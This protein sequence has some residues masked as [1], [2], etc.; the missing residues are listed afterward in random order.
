MS[1]EHES[2][3]R[4]PASQEPILPAQAS[5]HRKEPAIKETAPLTHLVK[6]T[7]EPH[8]KE[9]DAF[10]SFHL[11]PPSTEAPKTA[12]I[13]ELHLVKQIE[14]DRFSSVEDIK[15]YLRE[16]EKNPRNVSTSTKII[17]FLDSLDTPHQ[18]SELQFDHDTFSL[19]DIFQTEVMLKN[20]RNLRIHSEHITQLPKLGGKLSHLLMLNLTGCKNLTQL[21]EMLAKSPSLELLFLNGCTQLTTLPDDASS[22]MLEA[23]LD[24]WVAENPSEERTATVKIL[25]DFIENDDFD[26]SIDFNHHPAEL[27]DI[28]NVNL[29]TE[30]AQALNI[31]SDHLT[32]LPSSIV[33][34]TSYLTYLGIHCPNLTQLP[35]INAKRTNLSCLDLQGST[36]LTALP[37]GVS[38][39]T[40]GKFNLSGCTQL[41]TL[42]DN[43][44]LPMIEAFLDKWALEGAPHENRAHTKALFLD[45]LNESPPRPPLVFSEGT[46]AL[47][48]I[49]NVMP[50]RQLQYLNI[51]SP[52]ITSLPPS[53]GRLADLERLDLHGCTGLTALPKEIGALTKLELLDLSNCTS[54]THL[55]LEIGLLKR[56]ADLSLENCSNLVQVPETIGE[57]LKLKKL[58]LE[59]CIALT[60]LPRTLGNLKALTEL[61]LCGLTQLTA[62]PQELG[63]LERLLRL[64]LERCTQLTEV[65]SAI[66][67]L[68]RLKL[69]SLAGCTGLTTISPEIGRLALLEIF[70]LQDC[71]GLVFLPETIGNLKRL[72]ALLLKGC[73]AFDKL[74]VGIG[75]LSSLI[76]LQL[77][78]TP[79]TYLP[80]E[81]GHLTQLRV[82]ELDTCTHLEEIPE[83]LSNLTH[84]EL[85]QCT[86][87]SSLESIPDLHRLIA[88]ER[89][90]LSDC[91]KLRQLPNVGSIPKLEYLNLS[92]LTQMT[93]VSRS[94]VSA[95]NI[96]VIDL[97]GCSHLIALPDA[98]GTL[99]NLQEL[100]LNGCDQLVTLPQSLYAIKGHTLIAKIPSFTETL[101]AREHL[102]LLTR[103]FGPILDN[104]ALLTRALASR[105][106]Y[107][108]EFSK[109]GI[110]A[111]GL[112]TYFFANLIR[113][114][115]TELQMKRQEGGPTPILTHEG[116]FYQLAK[117]NEP[118]LSPQEASL[119]ENIGIFLAS[120][121]AGLTAGNK[122]GPIFPPYVYAALLY[123]YDHPIPE[124]ITPEA[125]KEHEQKLCM[126][127]ANNNS[128]SSIFQ[129]P[130]NLA[131]YLSGLMRQKNANELTREEQQTLRKLWEILAYI[132]EDQQPAQLRWLND[133]HGL[134]D[135]KAALTDAE[136]KTLAKDVFTSLTPDNAKHIETL[137]AE[138]AYEDY[139][140]G[141]NLCAPL[142]AVA[143]G[144]QKAPANKLQPFLNIPPLKQAQTQAAQN[145]SDVIQGPLV[146]REGCVFLLEDAS[147]ESEEAEQVRRWLLAWCQEGTAEQ[148]NE[149]PATLEQMQDM[150]SCFTGA[151]IMPNRITFH[152]LI[153]GA[154]KFHTCSKSVHPG[155]LLL[156]TPAKTQKNQEEFIE[157]WLSDILNAMN[158]GFQ[159][160]IAA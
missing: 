72:Q 130:D 10:V 28:F 138:N 57:L 128:S 80:K 35:P 93:Q 62:L 25:L 13:S 121:V 44:T 156:Q 108:D 30:K 54:L 69:L 27:P 32:T 160:E 125:M 159:D 109:R 100:N 116:G 126:V 39:P 48:D 91:T 147:V 40:I 136:L 15:A 59:N 78:G 144:F 4:Q 84:L 153:E 52:H 29:I 129:L 31:T 131:G 36:H 20:L 92:G 9:H 24:K 14:L 85:L 90:Y 7:L 18:Q 22:C 134:L 151:P 122:L 112:S 38:S 70:S 141:R 123:L 95:P 140:V 150:M 127:I 76:H 142:I 115:A 33:P 117:F 60:H 101:C 106:T 66:G 111:G 49:F 119:C 23:Y 11:T 83:E 158:S 71:T 21:P 37:E 3:P 98:I 94:I 55:P 120:A 50:L 74:P 139:R 42:P 118:R 12:A 102:K 51:D 67:R 43:A 157:Q 149:H 97:S 154:S 19:P 2:R 107:L 137:I 146:T 6:S 58:S 124:N 81:I 110:D 75:G 56:L 63:N 47:P 5:P 86:G 8:Q 64:G 53:I 65:P 16:W 82:L 114:I 133:K 143:K 113:N 26:T 104:P 17:A 87:C 99:H 61:N 88:L 103:A 34:L 77:T 105:V 155:T 41:T 145:L 1:I 152:E 68:T 46:F 45:F 148:P 79:L 135:P 73:T 96:R 132:P 89:L